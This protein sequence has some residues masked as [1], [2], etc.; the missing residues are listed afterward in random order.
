LRSLEWSDEFQRTQVEV[1]NHPDSARANYQAA[2]DMMQRTYESGGGNPMA[3]QMVQFH[4]RRA[5]ELDKN[6]KAALIGLLYLDCSAG[7]PK[8]AA[9]KAQLQERFATS[10]F[11]FGDRAVVQSL[12]ALLV[13]NRLCL[14]NSEVTALI[15]AAMSNPLIDGS[16]R[17][18]LYALAMDHAAAKMH[19]TPRALAYAQAAV[20]SDAGSVALRVNLIH[21]YI[22]SNEIDRARR[23]YEV[24]KTWKVPPRN[25]ASVD[26][27]AKLFDTL[28]KNANRRKPVS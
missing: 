23:E 27:L 10:R 15:D 22:Q 11:T 19:D 25:Q 9:I 24:L 20:A 21:L 1:S 7:V 12:S 3:Y 28:E 26:E 14:E 16:T 8:N 18:M 17:G 13:E 4:F 5:A 6:S 2:T